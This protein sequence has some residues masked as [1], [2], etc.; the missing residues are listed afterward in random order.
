MDE[1]I[2]LQRAT[3]DEHIRQE[4]AHQW[5]AVYDTFIQSDGDFYDVV[6]LNLRFGG[7]S[8]VKDFY[9]GL[10]AAFPD[11]RLSIWG[12]YDVPGC[13][14]RELTIE[15]THKG[16]WCGLAATGRRVKIHLVVL[17]LFDKEKQ[18]GKLLA[19]RVYF[20]N[21]SLMQQMRGELNPD[22]VADFSRM[23]TERAVH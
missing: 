6:P 19:E 9:V 1:I 22:S 21:Q 12:E 3:V 4:N 17:Y 15:A 10:E 20:D 7:F 11:F 23:Q 2:R 8:G 14:V 16:E 18:T 5:P 13:S